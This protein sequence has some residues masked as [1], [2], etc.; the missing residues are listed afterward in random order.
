MFSSQLLNDFQ[1]YNMGGYFAYDPPKQNIDINKGTNN[2]VIAIPIFWIENTS[3]I[4]VDGNH[5]IAKAKK[6]NEKAINTYLIHP[7]IAF[8]CMV[9]EFEKNIYAFFIWA[10]ALN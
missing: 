5:R 8:D 3:F 2:P 9:S 4:I 6:L 10:F 7:K 1:P